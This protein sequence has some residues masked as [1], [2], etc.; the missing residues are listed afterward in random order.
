MYDGAGRE[1][2]EMYIRK[3]LN[4]LATTVP[5]VVLIACLAPGDLRVEGSSTNPPVPKG[6][7]LG[8]APPGDEPTVFAPGVV[9]TSR[10]GEMGCSFSPDGREFY[11]GRSETSEVS[12]KWAIWVVRQKDG[13]W[14]EPEVASF[15]GVYR[16]FAPF[17]TPDGEH[18][19]F[20]RQGTDGESIRQGTWIVERRE[21]DWGEPRF[22]H[23]AYCMVTAD[24]HSFYFTT[25]RSEETSRD[26]ARLTFRDG[27][28]SEVQ[29]LRG[30]LNSREYDGHAYVA[31]GGNTLVF[32]SQRPGG[33]DGVDI[34]VSF[35]GSD[36][37][38]TKGYNLG[39]SINKGHRHVPSLSPD[40][41]FVFFSAD[42]D[43]HWASAKIIEELRDNAT[44]GD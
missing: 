20:F 16:D 37:S 1:D 41:R 29:E 27:T 19:L 34:Y 8:L 38:W 44:T 15:S 22:F 6:P 18:M 7:Y 14:Q 28:F 35:R 24:F 39:E 32:D 33:F 43:L 10:F 40:G 5:M 31:G 42:G 36:G 17:V 21:D 30:D 26:I 9:S 25:D 23:E 3:T 13:V 4:L 12:S 11:F 2:L